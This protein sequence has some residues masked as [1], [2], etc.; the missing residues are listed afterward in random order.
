[1]AD[2]EIE[3]PGGE[4]FEPPA[5]RRRSSLLPSLVGLAVAL[6][7]AAVYF[8]VYL[9]PAPAPAG[10]PA[11]VARLTT[12]AGEVKL[13]PGGRGAWKEAQPGDELRPGDQLRTEPRSGA[14]VTFFNGNVVRVRPDSLVLIGDPGAAPGAQSPGSLRV[15]SGRAN[16]EVRESAEIVT[17]GART[18]AAGQS[19]GD[20]DVAL[21]GE[22]GIKIFRGSAQVATAGGQT[23]TLGENEGVRVSRA[24]E[25]GD[26]VALPKPP[27]L[28]APLN[29][30]ELVFV[31][32][33][34]RTTRLEWTPSDKA[35]TYHLAMDYN[36]TQANLLLSAALDEPALRETGHD[37]S[38]LDAGKYYW[39][40]AGVGPEGM[41]GAYSRVAF[42][43]VLA[44]PQA[45]TGP[46][47]LVVDRLE[48]IG[49]VV[50]LRGRTTPGASLT[51]NGHPLAVET[52]GS[53]SEFLKRQTGALVLRAVGADGQE[54][55]VE[56]R[57]PGA[58]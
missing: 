22:T 54:T 18:T 6:V 38:G 36:V 25:A 34:G 28:L 24:G 37:L 2:P 45:E 9:K 50:Q 19:E 15:E 56:R 51:A 57:F 30:S 40:V 39:R 21:A 49:G 29:A 47:L 5:P 4:P 31:A 16:F 58:S 3:S 44:P 11:A 43:A 27:E 26:T 23:I 1:M 52:D 12:L 13:K 35:V 33:P 14:E 48:A 10:P 55:T 20:I 46:P 7:A 41:E 42:F 8:F 17:P 32:A 53:F